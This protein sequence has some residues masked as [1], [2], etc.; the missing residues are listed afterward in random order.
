MV[1]TETPVYSDLFFSFVKFD[2][3]KVAMLIICLFISYCTMNNFIL[4]ISPYEG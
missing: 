1:D 2:N 3:M 4:I